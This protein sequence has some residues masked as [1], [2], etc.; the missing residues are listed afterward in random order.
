M[1]AVKGKIHKKI[2]LWITPNLPENETKLDQKAKD[3]LFPA[4]KDYEEALM[5]KKKGVFLQI[6]CFF[7]LIL[8]VTCSQ[9]KQ[10]PFTIV[11]LPDTQNYSEKLP[12]YF[13]DQT[14]WIAE[15]EKT[16]NIAFVTHVGDIVQRGDQVLEEWEVAKEAMSR[17]DGLVPWGVAIGNHDYD[18]DGTHRNGEMFKRYFGAKRFQDKTWYGRTSP[19]GLSSFQTFTGGD[20]EFLIFHL[21]SDIPDDTIAWVKSVLEDHPGKPTILSTHIYL[22]DRT[23]SRDIK[24]Y[25]QKE[26]GNSAEQVWQKLIRKTPQ[27]FMVLCGHWSLAGGEWFQVSRNDA[28]Q[29]VFEILADYQQRENGGNGWLRYLQFNPDTNEIRAKTYSPS[30]GQFETDENSDFV[31]SVNFDERF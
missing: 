11:M 5:I 30:L 17:L 20:Q 6:F 26:S 9:I 13:H 25:W 27:I 8:P 14:K 19:D 28:G 23:Q 21:E 18:L 3:S 10:Q 22:D 15:Q 7:V 29:E 12:K 31:I 24:P 2:G 1:N 4:E 16:L